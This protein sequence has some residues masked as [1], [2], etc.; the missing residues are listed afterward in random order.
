MNAKRTTV[1]LFAAVLL[2]TAVALPAVAA[3]DGALT[4]SVEQDRGSGEAIV[5]VSQN[6]TAVANATVSVTASGNYS[7]DD[8]TTDQN[9]TVVLPAPEERVEATITALADGTNATETVELVPL[10][11]SLAVDV[12]Q[13]APDES[14][15]VTVT[16]YG[17]AVS[18]ATV[19]VS[20]GENETYAGTGTHTTDENGTV[21]LPA[22]AQPATVTIDASA[23]GLTAETT[24]TLEAAQP[25]LSVSVA[26]SADGSVTIDVAEGEEPVTEG[27]VTVE[28]STY[29][30]AGSYA[31]E[32]GTVSVPAPTQNVTVTVTATVGNDSVT[33]TADLIDPADANPNNDFAEDLGRFIQFLQS[34]DVD[35]GLGQQISAFVHEHNPA[36]NDDDRGPPEHAGN[37][38]EDAD[39]EG[40]PA[41]APGLSDGNESAEDG[42]GPP[43]HAG[44]NGQASGDEDREAD[45]DRDRDPDSHEE[46]TDESVA[47]ES[48]DQGDDD[49]PTDGDDEDRRGPPEHANGPP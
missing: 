43:D 26:Q 41:E 25:E 13:D 20:V 29:T 44:A 38:D 8:A 31:I 17:E 33:T 9:G 23:D 1:T 16:Q 47:A 34:Q 19:N 46:S 36:A 39:S 30:Y 18:N 48:T 4:V 22:P 14:A 37:G 15:T 5:A 27:T 6:G 28:S 45:Q 7:V 42:H 49:E 3:A 12:S 40:P 2:V 11:S 10:S 35:G 24:V 32:N 21:S